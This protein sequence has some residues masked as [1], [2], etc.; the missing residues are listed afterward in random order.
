MAIPRRIIYSC[1]SA[2]LRSPADIACRNRVK[3]LHPGWD[4]QCVLS[5]EAP[6]H[7]GYA[8]PEMDNVWSSL[9]KVDHRCTLAGLVALYKGGG[10]YFDTGIWLDLPLDELVDSNLVLASSGE[11]SDGDFLQVYGQPPGFSQQRYL[12]S[13]DVVACENGHWFVE[14][15]LAAFIQSAQE[16]EALRSPPEVGLAPNFATICNVMYGGRFGSREIVLPPP[17]DPLLGGFGHYGCRVS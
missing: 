11:L 5:S 9:A 8:W 3:E 7:F 1:Q 13:T 14:K 12:I 6:R 10:F 15:M 2:Y 4:I 16:Y 17:V